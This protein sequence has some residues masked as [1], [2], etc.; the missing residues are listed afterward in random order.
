MFLS[1]VGLLLV[2]VISLSPLPHILH[3]VNRQIVMIIVVVLVVIISVII[4]IRPPD[5]SRKAL[6]FTAV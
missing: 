5:D 6:H 3:N 1:S 4:I 2:A